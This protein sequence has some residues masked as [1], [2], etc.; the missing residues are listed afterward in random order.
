MFRVYSIAHLVPILLFSPL[1]T[2]QVVWVASERIYTCILQQHRED[3]HLFTFFDQ[4]ATFPFCLV[5]KLL[6]F[7]RKAG[8]LIN[9]ELRVTQTGN[10]FS[11]CHVHMLVHNLPS[12]LPFV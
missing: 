10:V 7:P 3:G 1:P 2:D 8:Q 11:Y 4:K 6:T 9:T 12:S 5:N